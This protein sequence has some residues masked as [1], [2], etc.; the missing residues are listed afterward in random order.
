[1]ALSRLAAQFAAEINLQDWSD[2]PH[3]ADKAGHRNEHDRPPAKRLSPEETDN[4]RK[5]VMWVTAQVLGYNDP[6][7]DEYEY[8]RACG[9]N[10][11]TPSGRPNSGEIRY[12]LRIDGAGRYQRPGT[13]E[14]DKD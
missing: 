9:V 10:T 6:N 4:I 5:N 14:V 2:A 7:F 8:A 13:Y 12:G 11:S 3:R 1:M